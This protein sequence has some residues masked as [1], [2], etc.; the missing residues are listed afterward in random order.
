[1]IQDGVRNRTRQTRLSLGISQAFMAK[2][3]DVHRCSYNQWELGMIDLSDEQLKRIN[4]SLRKAVELRVGQLLKQ[5]ATPA[6]EE[7]I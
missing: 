7:Q 5:F 1:M 3:S 4:D 6:T 2:D